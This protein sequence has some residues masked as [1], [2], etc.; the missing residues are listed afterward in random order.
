MCTP[1]YYLLRWSILVS[2]RNPCR[3]V[4]TSGCRTCRF[5]KFV[6][7]LE[8]RPLKEL[9]GCRAFPWISMK[10]QVDKDLNFRWIMFRKWSYLKAEPNRKAFS[11]RRRKEERE[12]KKVEAEKRAPLQIV[13]FYKWRRGEYYLKLRPKRENIS[14]SE[15]VRKG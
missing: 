8:G 5:L 11:S 3:S 2:L 10:Q 4:Y 9:S 7:Y 12:A 15:D 1:R 14:W 6:F 13:S